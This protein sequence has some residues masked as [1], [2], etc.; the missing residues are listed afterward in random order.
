MPVREVDAHVNPMVR[1]SLVRS[2]KK[3]RHDHSPRSKPVK[4]CDVTVLLQIIALA[5]RPRPN[6][7]SRQQHLGSTCRSTGTHY[8][9]STDHSYK[10]AASLLVQSRRWANC[11]TTG[12]SKTSE[13]YRPETATKITRHIIDVTGTKISATVMS[14][15]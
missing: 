2:G 1:R 6:Q 8:W 10:C 9:N 4:R 13:G 15:R 14:R 7:P 11:P 3:C 12:Y 5:E